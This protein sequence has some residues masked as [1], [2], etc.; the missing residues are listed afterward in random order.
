M[1]DIFDLAEEYANDFINSEDFKRLLELKEKIRKTLS[2]KIIA[3]KTKEAKYLE[4]KGYGG[5]HPNLKEY[6]LAFVEAKKSLYEEPL[7]VEYKRLE[8]GL[9][10]KLDMDM[11]DLKRVV[12]NKFKLSKII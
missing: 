6:Q 7:M 5:Y 10:K 9:Q 1:N 4:A 12:S 3:F 8:S 11:N 2:G